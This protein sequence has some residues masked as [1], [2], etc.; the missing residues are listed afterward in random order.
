MKIVAR[1]LLFL[2]VFLTAQP[3]LAV[4][5]PAQQQIENCTRPCCM[6]HEQKKPI[7]PMKGMCGELMCNPFG[8]YACCIGFVI[9]NKSTAQ[10]LTKTI[11]TMPATMPASYTYTF[12]QIC[13][14]PPENTIT[15]QA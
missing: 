3:V 8:Q 4:V 15:A 9:S 14:R 1:A 5:L 7:K 10:Q 13:W 2:F 11:E 12:S 6:Q